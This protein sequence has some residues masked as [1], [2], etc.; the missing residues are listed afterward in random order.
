MLCVFD[1]NGLVHR[2]YHGQPQ[3]A[4][5]LACDWVAKVIRER[6]PTH[7]A[8]AADRPFPTFRHELAPTYKQTKARMPE[9]PERVQVQEQLR[10]A[11][12]M[13]EDVLGVRTFAV[14]G[15]EG[16]DI[17]A[18]LATLGERA[19]LEVLVVARDK[20]FCQLVTETTRLLDWTSGAIVGPEEVVEKHGVAPEQFVD[21]LSIVGDSSDNV[22]GV[23]GCGPQA[24]VKV[25]TAF[26]SLKKALESAEAGRDAHPFWLA[27][28]KVWSRL[29]GGREA[30]SLAWRL[31]KLAVDV[32]LGVAVDELRAME[33]PE[34]FQ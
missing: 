4:G 18:S 12:E 22:P 16:D 15:Y 24:A 11:E 27:N 30:A 6:S 28:G 2:A 3:N 23:Y 32:D 29:A 31:V 10:I 9:G 25:L 33:L 19:G 17:V 13:L 20:D 7:V 14:R 5:R 34:L 21:Y 8:A 1:L 26:T